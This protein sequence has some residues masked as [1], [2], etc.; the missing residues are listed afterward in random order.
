M[1]NKVELWKSEKHGFDV[2]PDV[3][4]YAAAAT[5]MK[6]IDNADLERAQYHWTICRQLLDE[7][8]DAT[9]GAAK[10]KVTLKPA[11]NNFNTPNII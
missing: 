11:G 9:R 6:A 1:N 2:W 4:R 7:E 8:L 5:P 10:P 3:K